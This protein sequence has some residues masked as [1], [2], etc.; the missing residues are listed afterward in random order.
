MAF[1]NLLGRDN[2][3]STANRVNGNWRYNV[4]GTTSARGK[5]TDRNNLIDGQTAR[6]WVQQAK[7]DLL[8]SDGRL[9]LGRRHRADPM[10]FVMVLGLA[11]F[12]LVIIYSISSGLYDGNQAVI[13]REMG[14]R[15]AFLIAG[16]ITFFGVRAIPLDW[17]RKKGQW[18]FLAGLI[19][20][21]ALPILGALKVPMATCALGACR[22]YNLGIISFQ[23]AELLKLG[24]VLFMASYLSTRLANNKLNSTATLV[25]VMIVMIVSL[26]VIVGLQKDM[27]TGAALLAIFLTQ[28]VISGVSFRHLGLILMLML[29]MFVIMI[30]IAPHRLERIA[31]FTRAGNA[32]SDYHINQAML[33]LGSGGLTGR[34]LGQSVQ[35]YGWLP[36]AVNDSIFAIVGETL[37][38]IGAVGLMIA[39]S[40]LIL[41]ILNLTNYL[42]NMYLQLVVAGVVGWLSA[43]VLA[44]SMSMIH[45]IP[46]TGITLPL[47]SSGGTSLIFVMA[48]LGIVS[49]ISRYTSRRKIAIDD[50]EEERGAKNHEDSMRGRG[51][52]RTHNTYSSRH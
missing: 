44:N 29:M 37:G 47:V 18:I 19:I 21:I 1:Y 51:Q 16:V 35:A 5:W 26:G 25:E 22:W 32:D 42:N 15:I 40:F 34:G 4:S 30:I 28:L 11:F 39:F 49:S 14:K 45:L 31:T 20:C 48:S 36:E 23:P 12:G 38:F 9:Q 8:R 7:D 6:A 46:L 27:G 52:W 17:L 33:A 10:L 41:R 3:K 24:T 13:N 2:N 50:I 43:H